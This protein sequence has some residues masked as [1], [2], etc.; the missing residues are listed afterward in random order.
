MFPF[1]GLAVGSRTAVVIYAS[2]GTGT[3]DASTLRTRGAEVDDWLISITWNGKHKLDGT[4]FATAT[5]QS[6][7]QLVGADLDK[8]MSW[9]DGAD[10]AQPGAYWI[11][12]GPASVNNSVLSA[13]RTASPTVTTGYTRNAKW[14]GH[15][16]IVRFFGSNGNVIGSSVTSPTHVN[17]VMVGG[18]PGS[19]SISGQLMLSAAV[20][21]EGSFTWHSSPSVDDASDDLT[22]FEFRGP[23]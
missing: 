18:D 21:G 16:A 4:A 11:V 1:S 19:G 13:T 5:Y 20:Y 17:N 6:F 8:A 2:P 7:R 23:S 15:I 12:R 22:V 9:S 14:L 3:A 10:V